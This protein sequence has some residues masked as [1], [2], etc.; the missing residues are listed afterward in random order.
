MGTRT[1]RRAGDPSAAPAETTPESA[2]IAPAGRTRRARALG[3]PPPASPPID[4]ARDAGTPEWAVIRDRTRVLATPVMLASATVIVALALLLG[5]TAVL[6]PVV[7]GYSVLAPGLALVRLLRLGEPVLEAVAGI[8]VSVSLAGLLALAQVYTGLWA[9]A[10][11]TWMLVGL[12]AVA[13]A[14]DPVIVP[15]SARNRIRTRLAP[16]RAALAV[17][18]GRALAWLAKPSGWGAESEALTLDGGLRARLAGRLTARQLRPPVEVAV[19]SAAARRGRLAKT[20]RPTT[21]PDHLLEPPRGIGPTTDD[22]FGGLIERHEKG[23]R[24]ETDAGRERP[25]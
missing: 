10:M 6:A 15:A 17:A 13:L 9:P 2:G 22:F 11:V 24:P 3:T 1:R 14:G 23:E 18:R 16:V 21:A 5:A 19:P 4:R 20:G 8:V 7:I 12:T 25:D